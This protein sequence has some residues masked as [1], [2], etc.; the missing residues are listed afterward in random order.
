[1]APQEL[2]EAAA[3]KRNLLPILEVLRTHL[4][5]EALG[6]PA[7][8]ARPEHAPSAKKPFRMGARA[9]RSS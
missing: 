8:L 6:L 5:L 1:M 4:S 3:A 2:P 7:G 9:G